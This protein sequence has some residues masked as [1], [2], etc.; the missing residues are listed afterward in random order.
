MHWGLFLAEV[1]PPSH[2]HITFN[3]IEPDLMSIE[4][5]LNPLDSD[6]YLVSHKIV[7]TH[8]YLPTK[9]A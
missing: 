4:T 1:H 9:R 5:C 3:S 6:F 2:P 8:R 7:V